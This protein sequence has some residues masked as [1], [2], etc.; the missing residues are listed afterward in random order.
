MIPCDQENFYHVPIP[1]AETAEVKI[2]ICS[3]CKEEF[4]FTKDKEGR[5]DNERYLEVHARSHLQ[6]GHPHFEREYGSE[7][8]NDKMREASRHNDLVDEEERAMNYQSN[9]L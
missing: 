1:I 6:P 3:L 4:Y 5:V 7:Q 8:A 9:V 2:E